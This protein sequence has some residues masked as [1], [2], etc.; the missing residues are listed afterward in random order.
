MEKGKG[1][2]PEGKRTF[3]QRTVSP[4]LRCCTAARIAILE[5]AGALDHPP[6]RRSVDVV[7]WGQND[8]WVREKTVVRSV[9]TLTRFILDL[10]KGRQSIPGRVTW[11]VEQL[12]VVPEPNGFDIVD[13]ELH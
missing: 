3:S 1:T 11:L 8:L 7:I 5:I 9:V 4:R 2:G 13:D 10:C 6:G 12:L